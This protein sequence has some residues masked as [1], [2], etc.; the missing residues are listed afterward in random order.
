MN[1][2]P[3]DL[4]RQTA[5]GHYSNLA[6]ISH[7]PYEFVIDF[8]LITPQ[9][10]ALVGARIILSPPHAKAFAQS[11][12]ENLARYEANFGPIPEPPRETPS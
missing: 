11:L 10:N 3:L 9:G 8:A 2:I 6:L 7:T 12:L 1:E 4:D 5:L